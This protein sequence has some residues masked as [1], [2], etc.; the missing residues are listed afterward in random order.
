MKQLFG[1]T[2]LCLRDQEVV[3][4]G[5]G[6]TRY[7]IVKTTWDDHNSDNGI[8]KYPNV[9]QRNIHNSKKW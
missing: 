4:D 6:G 2:E 7:I 1:L 8:G 5:Q 9:G 3:E